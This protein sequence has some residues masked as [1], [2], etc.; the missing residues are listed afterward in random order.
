MRFGI[1]MKNINPCNSSTIILHTQIPVSQLLNIIHGLYG[2]VLGQ[3]RGIGYK[4]GI[5]DIFIFIF[6]VKVVYVIH[7]LECFSVKPATL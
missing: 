6:I 4:E 1:K 3:I 7:K 2:G 5:M